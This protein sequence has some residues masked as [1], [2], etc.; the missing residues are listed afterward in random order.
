MIKKLKE[1]MMET[2][3]MTDLGQ[4]S[5]FLGIESTKDYGIQ[6]EYNED[7]R[8]I[9]CTNSDWVESAVDMKSTSGYTFSLG[10]SIFSWTSKKQD[11]GAIFSRDRVRRNNTN[12]KSRYLTKVY[13]WIHG[14]TKKI[15]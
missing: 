12:D 15:L 3:E 13:T 4:M 14:N 8:L 5:Y 2:F 1:D 11:C 7:T 10:S 9:G 6:Y